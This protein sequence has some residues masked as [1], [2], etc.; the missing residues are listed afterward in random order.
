MASVSLGA[1]RRREPGPVALAPTGRMLF[2]MDAPLTMLAIAGVYAAFSK[3]LDGEGCSQAAAY[4]IGRLGGM[5]QLPAYV[6]EGFPCGRPV[7]HQ[8]AWLLMHPSAAFLLSAD[9]AHRCWA[10]ATALLMQ[11]I[12]LLSC[13]LVRTASL[14]AYAGYGIRLRYAYLPLLRIVPKAMALAQL[15][16]QGPIHTLV[17][18]YTPGAYTQHNQMMTLLHVI[19]TTIGYTLDL[20]ASFAVVFAELLISLAN[21]YVLS[22]HGHAMWTVAY[23][24]KITF[25]SLGV[26]LLLTAC[27][28][29]W[30][31]RSHRQRRHGSG[32]GRMGAAGRGRT[33]MGAVA[34]AAKVEAHV[35]PVS[36]PCSAGTSGEASGA[37]PLQQHRQQRHEGVP[38]EDQALVE[39]KGPLGGKDP[40]TGSVSISSSFASVAGD[41][42]VAGVAA[43]SSSSGSAG[44][45]AGK[46]GEQQQQRARTA[47]AEK[48][49]PCC[50][51]VL[52]CTT[53]SL[54]EADG[55]QQAPV[56]TPP[57]RGVSSSSTGH[58]DA[59]APAPNRSTTVTLAAGASLLAAAAAAIAANNRARG[60]GCGGAVPYDD[61]E[62]WA[63]V[64]L[65][66]Q[67][68]AQPMAEWQPMF[69]RQRVSIK[70]GLVHVAVRIIKVG[71]YAQA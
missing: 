71:S 12:W 55:Q 1:Q 18:F 59:G 67:I 25:I 24:A 46:A 37:D 6:P 50:S 51:N 44:S 45:L 9:P 32:D 58:V 4:T 39:S 22:M 69:T 65:V 33:G 53:P 11:L 21:C 29:G 3:Y 31:R 48:V 8:A 43:T 47:S 66:R 5:A 17:H 52:P 2:Y 38:A 40:H 70:V 7:V 68:L 35:S 57:V 36:L 34:V 30:E 56:V 49:V 41:G 19:L 61:P 15:I 60:G 62:K 42:R 54:F 13:I 26:P 16:A 28:S 63:S 20:S 14:S 10:F 27:M 64:I 23:V